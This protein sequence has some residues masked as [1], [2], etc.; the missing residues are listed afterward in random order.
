MYHFFFFLTN[1]LLFKEKSDL[2]YR[3]CFALANAKNIHLSFTTL[4]TLLFR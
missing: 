2:E 4:G 1:Q 3:A